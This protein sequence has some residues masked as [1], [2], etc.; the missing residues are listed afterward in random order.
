MPAGLLKA[1]GSGS[2]M[3]D[4]FDAPIPGESLT[5]PPRQMPYDRPPQ[6]PDVEDALDYVM[7]KI[8][9]DKSAHR[10]LALM[11]VGFPVSKIVELITTNGAREGYWSIA[12]MF[13]VAPPLTS[14]ILRMAEAAK[15]QPVLTSK[16]ANAD[17]P[18][19]LMRIKRTNISTQSV[20]KAQ[21]AANSSKDTAKKMNPHNA[22][23]EEK[24]GFLMPGG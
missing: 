24:A 1:K 22:A 19:A 21:R 12:Q 13:L 20:D 2:P 7:H 10:L 23:S 4:Q 15:I 3:V 16:E 9:Q 17:L 14:L 11:E 8:V 18:A 6:F 5:R